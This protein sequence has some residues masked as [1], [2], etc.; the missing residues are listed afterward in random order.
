[1]DVGKYIEIK[2]ARRYLLSRPLGFVFRII[3]RRFV[4]KTQVFNLL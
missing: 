1:M 2:A 4:M 3:Q